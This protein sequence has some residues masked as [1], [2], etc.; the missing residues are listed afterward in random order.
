M[1]NTNQTP[2]ILIDFFSLCL[3][4]VVLVFCC[5]VVL[6]FKRKREREAEEVGR[7]LGGVGS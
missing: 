2:C 7:D 6:V 1:F 4:F 3:A 5:F